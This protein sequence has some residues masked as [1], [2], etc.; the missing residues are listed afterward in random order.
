[1]EEN[2]RAAAQIDEVVET[3]LTRFWLAHG[4]RLLLACP[5]V[6]AHVGACIGGRRLVPYIPRK[7]LPSMREQPRR[8]PLPMEDL[9]VED[10]VD[11]PTIG[12]WVHAEHDE[13]DAVRCADHLA[14]SQGAARV[15]VTDRRVA[16]LCPTKHLT[17]EPV[18]DDNVFTTLEEMEPHRLVGLDTPFLGRSVPPRRIIAFTFADGSELYSYDIHATLKVRRAMERAHA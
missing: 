3:E 8:W 14:A 16:V 17:D 5:P 2:P 12:H 9:P 7:E 6:R 11:D 18:A 1:M 4:E 10:W 15:V 13:Q